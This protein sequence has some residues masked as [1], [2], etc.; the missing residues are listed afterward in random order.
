LPEGLE[1]L[2][3]SGNP[4]EFLLDN[5]P[6]SLKSLRADSCGIQYLPEMKGSKLE[7]LSLAANGLESI[8]ALRGLPLRSLNVRMNSLE[9]VEP[10]R[11]CR[12]LEVLNVEWNRIRTIEPISKLKLKE[13]HCDGNRIVSLVPLRS[14]STLAT[15]SMQSN[16]ISDLKPLGG[17]FSLISLDVS[18]NPID[19]LAPL[20]SLSLDRLLCGDCPLT[21]FGKALSFPP[22][23]IF[24]I[25][26]EELLSEDISRMVSTLGS[27]ACIKNFESSLQTLSAF[28]R[29]DFAELKRNSFELEG[30]RFTMVATLRNFRDAKSAAAKA[31]AALPS[32]T[33]Q[34]LLQLLAKRLSTSF[35]TDEG[36]SAFDCAGSPDSQTRLLP[37]VFEWKQAS[38]EQQSL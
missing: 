13:L 9:S 31:G 12:D 10:L 20:D 15:L 30:R 19:S 1:S 29:E 3:I 33:S 22:R 2:D 35:W 24:V 16:K 8:E 23:R 21:S 6:S 27:G 38:K 14:M 17:L 25:D 5:P 11:G 18:S 34:E 36:H 28:K 7:E 4:V 37:L 32:E 26:S